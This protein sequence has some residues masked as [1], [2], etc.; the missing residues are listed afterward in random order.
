MVDCN[1]KAEVVG[2]FKFD[3]AEMMYYLYFPIFIRELGM[4]DHISLEPR[5]ERYRR[6]IMHA[7]NIESQMSFANL[8]FDNIYVSAKTMIVGPNT[9]GNRPGWHC[10][11]FGTS[12]V[13]YIWCDSSPT[14]FSLGDF[15]NITEDH[16]ES[17]KQFDE[18]AEKNVFT[19]FKENS[20]IRLTNKVVHHTPKVWKPGIRSF[21]K[22][23][24]SNLKYN[25]KGN[26]RNYALDTSKWEMYSREEIRNTPT[27]GN[28]DH[29]P[30]NE[31]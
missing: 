20:L 6:M 13:N 16:V 22:I 24:F 21:V 4:T 12:D 18:I 8:S 28:T 29:G 7:I 14:L 27:Y 25:L 30:Q 23:S 15:S 19:S 11:G 5:L 26:T 2:T 10:D 9:T 1:D 31:K 17:L 3:D